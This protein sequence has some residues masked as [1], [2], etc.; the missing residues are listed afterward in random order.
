MSS[1][2]SPASP[3]TCG[4]QAGALDERDAGEHE[5]RRGDRGS[6]QRQRDPPAGADVA[7]LQSED[8][9]RGHRHE[10]GDERD[11]GPSIDHGQLGARK[12]AF[13]CAAAFARARGSRRRTRPAARR[14]ATEARAARG[15]ARCRVPA[16]RRRRL[17]R[18]RAAYTAPAAASATKALTAARRD[19]RAPS[20]AANWFASSAGEPKRAS[21]PRRY[22]GDPRTRPERVYAALRG[23][24][25]LRARG[26]ARPGRP[27]SRHDHLDGVGERLPR[28]A[29][30]RELRASPLRELVDAAAPATSGRRPLAR[31]QAGGL[32]PVKRRIDRALREVERAIARPRSLSTTP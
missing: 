3:A 25:P 7:Q 2:R 8:R 28:L 30:A 5:Q 26:S 19:D 14:S 4:P 29:L 27:R 31:E 24:R 17:R 23:C 11:A 21:A 32:Q 16:A 13:A 20:S 10:A 9:E 6:D 15:A 1:K 18:T 22:A 12:D